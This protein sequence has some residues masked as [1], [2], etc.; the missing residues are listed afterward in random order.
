MPPPHPPH[1]QSISLN[2][3]LSHPWFLLISA[4]YKVNLIKITLGLIFINLT[5]PNSFEFSDDTMG[6][7]WDRAK[8]AADL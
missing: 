3:I 8:G 1:P 4:V 2:E 6:V 7:V 5:R